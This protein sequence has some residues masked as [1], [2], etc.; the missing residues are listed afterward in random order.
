MKRNIAEFLYL[1]KVT[2]NVYKHTIT[3]KLLRRNDAKKY[4]TNPFV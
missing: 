2:W 4:L 1:C 3:N